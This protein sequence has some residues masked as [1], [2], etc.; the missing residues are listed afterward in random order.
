MPLMSSW[1]S[2]LASRGARLT[3]T[4][5][6]DFGEPVGEAAAARDYT[7]LADLSHNALVSITGDD[8]AAFLHAQFTNDVQALPIGSAQWNGWCTAKGRLLATFLLLRRPEGYLLMLPGEIAPAVIK[9][10]G[11]FVLRSKVK[12]A[13]VSDQL[14]RMA[15]AG[16]S[17][18]VIVG[19]QWGHAPD[20]M[21]SV[22]K[23][24]TT[25]VALD[26]ERF[27]ILAPADKA[28]AVWEGLAR[29][30]KPAGADAWELSLI[31]AGI[32]TVT[33][34]TQEEFV[35]QM[36]N[37]ELIGGL[38]F[39]KGCYP[40]QEIVARTQYRG[41]LKKRM[42]RAHLDGDERPAPG[43][44]VYSSAFGE[45]AAGTIV[46]VA[47]A[48]DGGFDALVVAQ[49]ESLS[50]GDLRWNSPDGAPLEIRAHLAAPDAAP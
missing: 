44:K 1:L 14:V 19:S 4:G 27:V 2:F 28:P 33:A 29:N 13:D 17:A 50:Q 8:A 41:I 36:A 49:L 37:F 40:G 26:P 21:R 10:L 48:P 45:Q 12:I 9:R 32:P 39:K 47:A 11:M 16:K 42:V 43:Q 35:P 25:A 15:F 5:V 46:N 31:H 38:S 3:A 6:A 24:G 7:I 34:A 22:E 20:P 30:A 18:G 23:D